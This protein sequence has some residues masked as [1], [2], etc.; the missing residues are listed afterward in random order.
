MLT[1]ADKAV[2]QYLASVTTVTHGVLHGRMP[3]QYRFVAAPQ[4][5][6]AD[7]AKRFQLLR[8]QGLVMSREAKC[9][10][11]FLGR[12]EQRYPPKLLNLIGTGKKTLVYFV[13]QRIFTYSPAMVIAS[14]AC[15]CQKRDL[16]VAAR[17]L[18][19]K[20]LSASTVA[21]RALVNPLGAYAHEQDSGGSIRDVQA[22][23]V[24]TEE[25]TNLVCR[26]DPSA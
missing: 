25:I 13:P 17:G 6:P 20:A 3:E 7:A 26:N 21:T 18:G 2:Q 4:Y 15:A 10:V 24:A 22:M 16:D 11:M 12:Q 19:L 9:G 23:D 14:P 8:H 1:A 5:R